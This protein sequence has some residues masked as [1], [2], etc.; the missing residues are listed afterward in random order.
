[1]GLSCRIK[2]RP[3]SISKQKTGRAHR[4]ALALLFVASLLAFGIAGDRN[5]V[6]K[7][8]HSSSEQAVT[9]E[10]LS[11]VDEYHRIVY[12]EDLTQP[13]RV[14]DLCLGTNGMQAWETE[15]EDL[16]AAGG[17]FRIENISTNAPLD[18]D[19]DGIHDLHELQH[20][21]LDALNA[22]D[23]DEDEDGDL[24][25]NREEIEL[26]ADPTSMDSDGDGFEDGE[27][28]H[29][30]G[31]D[32]N[33]ADPVNLLEQIEGATY[34][35][36][37]GGWERRASTTKQTTPTG[38]VTY[39][40]YINTPG[41]HF[42]DILT[43]HDIP[44]GKP[45]DTRLAC[46]IDDEYVGH[47]TITLLPGEMQSTRF[48]LPYHPAAQYRDL[49]L[50]SDTQHCDTPLVIHAINLLQLPGVDTNANNIADWT[51][52]VLDRTTSLEVTNADNP[53]SFIIEG[54]GEYLSGISSTGL[55]IHEGPDGTWFALVPWG[56]SMQKTIQVSFQNGGIQRSI[57]AIR[58]PHNL[59]AGGIVCLPGFSWRDEEE[60]TGYFTYQPAGVSSG[61][62]TLDLDYTFSDDDTTLGPFTVGST[63]HIP[64][65]AGRY[66]YNL[67]RI[68]VKPIGGN[69]LKSSLSYVSRYTTYTQ[70]YEGEIITYD[71]STLSAFG[72]GLHAEVESPGGRV[73]IEVRSAARDREVMLDRCPD[74]GFI[75][76]KMDVRPYILATSG[77]GVAYPAGPDGKERTL[78]RLVGRDVPSTGRYL[79]LW[80]D[81][82]GSDEF[83]SG[84]E[85]LP[86]DPSV[87]REQG[88]YKFFIVH[89]PESEHPGLNWGYYN[90]VLP[91]IDASYFQ[92]YDYY[93]NPGRK[94]DELPAH[95]PDASC[96]VPAP[97]NCATN[98]PPTLQAPP[99]HR[100]SSD[101]GEWS[102]L[103]SKTTPSFA[104]EATVND[105]CPDP[106]VITYTD[107]FS[108]DRSDDDVIITRTWRATD[109][110]GAV[111]SAVQYITTHSGVS[112]A[113][114]I[115]RYQ[116]VE[117]R[118]DPRVNPTPDN[119]PFVI[120]SACTN[121]PTITYEDTGIYYRRYSYLGFDRTWTL[122]NNCGSPPITFEQTFFI[123][124]H[125]APVPVPPPDVVIDCSDNTSPANTGTATAPDPC[126][127]QIVITY[128]DRVLDPGCPGLIERIWKASDASGNSSHAPQLI[129]LA[130]NEGLVIVP[131]PDFHSSC[132]AA[133]MSTNMTGKATATTDCGTI[134]SITFQDEQLSNLDPTVRRE[135]FVEDSCGRT[136]SV[137]QTLHSD[138]TEKPVVTAPPMLTHPCNWPSNSTNTNGRATV[139]DNCGISKL[140]YED[141]NLAQ[142]DDRY[143]YIHRIWTAT[144]T[145][146]N[147]DA[148]TQ[149]IRI[150][151]Q[152]DLHFQPV[153][154]YSTSC[155]VDTVH[156]NISG[157]PTYIED[158]GSIYLSH[159]DVIL[160]QI[161]SR[162][163]IERTWVLTDYRGSTIQTQS[164]TQRIT[165]NYQEADLILP[166]DVEIEGCF[167]NHAPPPE[168]TGYPT[169][170]N[171]CGY[172]TFRYED[173]L[174]NT[175]VGFDVARTWFLTAPHSPEKSGIQQIRVITS[176]D[177]IPP[178]LTVPAD[179]VLTGSSAGYPTPTRT[180]AVLL[181]TGVATAEDLCSP[182]TW[183][184]FTDEWVGEQGAFRIQRTWTTVDPKGN[185]TNAVQQ[186]VLSRFGSFRILGP[187]TVHVN[188]VEEATPDRTGIPTLVSTCVDEPIISYA[189]ELQ[190]TACEIT[191]VRTWT[192]QT[193]RGTTTF[194]HHIIVPQ[195][196]RLPP[197]VTP[198]PFI[199]VPCGTPLTTNLTGLATANDADGNLITPS[200]ADYTFPGVGCEG[201]TRRRWSAIDACGVT[202]IAD[203][204]IMTSNTNA[205]M[206]APPI[207]KN[208]GCDENIAPE[209]TGFATAFSSD[210]PDP[211]VVTYVD[212]LVSNTNILPF[213]IQRTW[214]A[215]N[216]CGQV[217][218]VVQNIITVD[219]LSPVITVPPDIAVTSLVDTGPNFTGV[220]TAV[221][222]CGS[223][224]I[225]FSDDTDRIINETPYRIYRTWTVTDG[226]GRQDQDIQ[227]IFVGSAA[228]T[229]P[230]E[231][232]G[233]SVYSPIVDRE[234]ELVIRNLNVMTDPRATG[235]GPWAFWTL[236]ERI[237]APT[238]PKNFLLDWL[239]QWE[240]TQTV[241]GFEIPTRPN[242]RRFVI[243]PWKAKDHPDHPTIRDA[244]WVMQPANVPFRLLSIVNRTDLTEE[245]ENGDV[246]HAGEGRFVFGVRGIDRMGGSEIDL[247]FSVIMEFQLA[248]T[249]AATRTRWAQNWRH[250]KEVP[251]GD[252]YN[253]SLQMITDSFATKTHFRRLR[254][255]EN[256]LDAAWEL[257]E[258]RL[259]ANDLLQS[260]PT[261][262]TPDLMSYNLPG[263]GNAL[264]AD[265]IISNRASI[266]AGTHE[267]PLTIGTNNL[268]FLGA[269]ALTISAWQ[270]V[271]IDPDVRHAFSRNTCMGCHLAETDTNFRHIA[272]KAG[273]EAVLSRYLLSDSFTAPDPV[274]PGR[275]NTIQVMGDRK[276]MLK[277]L[278][279]P[280]ANGLVSDPRLKSLIKSN[281]VR[282]H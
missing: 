117:S 63:V 184:T 7:L 74:S 228:I 33:A 109:A 189:D 259:N 16:V 146:G 148:S 116:L 205:L 75:R 222:P 128:Q 107:A 158:C 143:W 13:W 180:D 244:D 96:L 71:S 60:H 280:P 62:F 204:W 272:A 157:R 67:N 168:L 154:D 260:S 194:T 68:T 220:A 173:A 139:T 80:F 261:P 281:K 69:S 104:G 271:G 1:M 255:N 188:S 19:E 199:R 90:T 92:G 163:V 45:A 112:Q 247:P 249:D 224:T 147:T 256:A 277:A 233:Q 135:W 159:S 162:K 105:D 70:R 258:F 83:E 223:F 29:L 274:I 79:W 273:S 3:G 150:D 14:V 282:V 167:D 218:Q 219:T 127:E 226:V 31:T 134:V 195:P 251:Y 265:Y 84:W 2:K 35:S 73:N 53:H 174:S 82:K 72:S 211:A 25:T 93:N 210:C 114:G 254:T 141:H 187:G 155:P 113:L 78:H 101:Y 166:L 152:P 151:N 191:I 102:G 190:P 20:D 57:T 22:D 245:N 88:E 99:F 132:I 262:Q 196:P 121:T 136:D 130:G 170:T 153:P 238:D 250:L 216:S 95:S 160:E 192:F 6:L 142:P 39:P 145:S 239:A 144:D 229:S 24:L 64:L 276:A 161:P 89:R 198:P 27:E 214:T 21:F 131:P 56:E 175:S 124:D 206:I 209:H 81:F 110:C 182:E 54:K 185:V 98:S 119:P 242:M 28:V 213:S 32:P 43:S 18:L 193:C 108:G 200:F 91:V 149:I 120:P 115:E 94:W 103:R 266:I 8:R 129:T 176:T 234:K 66:N 243:D 26:R 264:L 4:A 12:K 40:I 44:L 248:A 178:V 227:T 275:V 279:S 49:T 268:P 97:C 202:S 111:T 267:V 118:C 207:D 11:T 42:V 86:I 263:P 76:M 61:H 48:R 241:N 183:T 133:N 270:A 122:V 52:R 77:D 240:N 232:V 181:N 236:I 58:S 30:M 252:T 164:N 15:L 212:T 246:L 230:P 37:Q 59:A 231:P 41:M 140:K 36:S 51:D 34:T 278:A 156:P 171:D 217:A 235:A 47:K 125:E 123:N 23:A 208:L 225:D 257:R 203:Q 269:N 138:D 197:T 237:A 55:D 46:Y 179:L 172:A 100:A 221:D 169:A 177:L 126:G 201:L 9:L 106:P 215:S 50:V 10:F 186:I 17:Y 38:K 5:Q 165:I 85:Q 253:Q 65:R 137:Y 87:I